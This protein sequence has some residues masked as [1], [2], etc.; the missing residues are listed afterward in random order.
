MSTL[1]DKTTDALKTAHEQH[2]P[3]A[4]FRRIAELDVAGYTEGVRGGAGDVE[5][6]M[7]QAFAPAVNAGAGA[8]GAATLSIDSIVVNVDG[9][10]A[11]GEDLGRRIATG[12]ED[13]LEVALLRFFERIARRKGG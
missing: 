7:G 12:I 4:L 13:Q 2:S 10:G 8:A 11:G 5:D 3:S 9:H 1:A 6:A